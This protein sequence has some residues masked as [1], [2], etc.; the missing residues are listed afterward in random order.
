MSRS[1]GG[2]IARRLYRDDVEL[3]ILGF[4]GVLVV[5]LEQTDANNLVADAIDRGVNYF[6]VAPTYGNG[7]A[8]ERLGVALRPY[9]DGVFL[10]C[11]TGCRDA[12]G[13]QRELEQSL[14]RLQT[15]Y[16][17]LY[18]FHGVRTLEQ[19]EEIFGPAGASE[20]FLK[21][22]E[23]GRVRFIGF[24]AHSV[25][26]ALAMLDRFEFDSV[27]F[28]INYVCYAQ[29]NFG[30]QVVQRAKE[31]GVSRLAMKTLAY[32]NWPQGAEREYPKCWYRPASEPELARQA[33]RF[34]L[35]EDITA[36]VAP[37]DHRLFPLA[38]QLAEEFEPLTSGERQQLLASAEGL[39]P[40]FPREP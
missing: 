10:A 26:A 33:L 20:S 1:S 4:G 16:V 39:K 31:T 37:G 9:R 28:P 30:P 22:R 25:E 21:A 2:A 36:A 40:I 8:E 18:Q 34:T 19:V 5:G 12:E 3:S 24:S 15:G 23:G 38:L 6:D 17:D 29:G 35:S 32:T 27:L 11:K 13:V 7:E 14:K